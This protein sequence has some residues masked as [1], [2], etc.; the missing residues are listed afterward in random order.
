MLNPSRKVAM[1]PRQLQQTFF[2]WI[3][4]WIDKYGFPTVAIVFLYFDFIYPMKEER[5]EMTAVI[6]TIVV[7]QAKMTEQIVENQKKTLENQDKIMSNQKD[8]INLSKLMIR[9]LE[10]HNIKIHI[11]PEDRE[12]ELRKFLEE[13]ECML[14]TESNTEAPKSLNLT[15]NKS[16]SS[17]LL[18]PSRVH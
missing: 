4:R 1:S 7:T 18:D 12:K 15:R 3:F 16:E 10:E 11:A 9:M 6:S 2:S 5:K 17:D 14:D 8:I 13:N